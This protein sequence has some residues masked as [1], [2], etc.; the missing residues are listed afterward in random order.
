MQL[1]APLPKRRCTEDM[2]TLRNMLMVQLIFAESF[3][4]ILSNHYTPHLPISFNGFYE[5]ATKER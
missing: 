2:E 4:L 3:P 5:S 1:S